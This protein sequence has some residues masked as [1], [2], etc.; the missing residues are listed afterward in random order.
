MGSAWAARGR[1]Q[2]P[3]S[4]LSSMK[5][6]AL[7]ELAPTPT[8]PLKA[9]LKGSEFS[10]LENRAG[11]VWPLG[12]AWWG[13]GPGGWGRGT[14]LI[15]HGHADR[16]GLTW[17]FQALPAGRGR[18]VTGQPLARGTRVPLGWHPGALPVPPAHG[19]THQS[20]DLKRMDVEQGD[21]QQQPPP[22]WAQG[23]HQL[24]L[25]S[26]MRKSPGGL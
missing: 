9:G 1:F 24:C 8:S 2:E 6:I 17:P 15:P 26:V 5:H 12:S 10:R 19:I 23:H 14:Y 3:A 4:C 7:S 25:G 22:R 21:K 18:H 16:A 20:R 11:P 13:P